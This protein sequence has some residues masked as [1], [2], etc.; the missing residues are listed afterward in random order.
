MLYLNLLHTTPSNQ[1]NPHLPTKPADP[2]PLTELRATLPP[3]TAFWYLRMTAWFNPGD[4]GKVPYNEKL[5]PSTDIST[6]LGVL[7]WD[8]LLTM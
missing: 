1:V 5:C 4:L 3:T 8:S 2:K 6:A 7:S